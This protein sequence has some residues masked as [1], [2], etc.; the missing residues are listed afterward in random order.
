MSRFFV[1]AVVTVVALAAVGTSGA[2]TPTKG[3]DTREFS[4]VDNETC[5]FPLD[6]TVQ[7][8]RTTTVFDNGDEKRHVDLTVTMKANGKTWIDRDTYNIFISA[9]SNVWDIV[10]AFT[11]T[12]AVGG[13]TILL[14]SG[15][16]AYDAATDTLVDLH[17]GPHGTGADPDAY[18]S[19]VCAAL[20]P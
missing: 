17:P 8:V 2:A 9:D 15:R 16:L 7:R 14:E 1:T 12:R 13:G 18:A 10:G 5:A 20:A 4:F 19:A 6:G 11:H 3:T